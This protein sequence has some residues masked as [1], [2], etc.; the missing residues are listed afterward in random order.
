VARPPAGRPGE[1]ARRLNAEGLRTTRSKQGR[2]ARAIRDIVD[3]PTCEG[4]L[5]HRDDV[6]LALRAG[7]AR[8]RRARR[9]EAARRPVVMDTSKARRELR[10]RPRHDAHE[11]LRETVA[12]VEGATP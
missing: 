2:R 6:A 12:A 1:I 10:W 5:V 7:R 4:R 8:P 9:I 11:T 3:N